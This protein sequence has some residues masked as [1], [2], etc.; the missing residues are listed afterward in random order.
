VSPCTCGLPHPVLSGGRFVRSMS[1][2]ELALDRGVDRL[3]LWSC[4][5]CDRTRAHLARALPEPV[6]PRLV[7]TGPNMARTYV[8]AP[9]W[10]TERGYVHLVDLVP[11]EAWDLAP[12]LTQ[13]ELDELTGIAWAAAMARLGVVAICRPGRR[14]A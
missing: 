7:A 13:T 4:V 5:A 14:A 6:L 10:L 8:G 9:I 3:D 1:R 12:R 2:D 11:S